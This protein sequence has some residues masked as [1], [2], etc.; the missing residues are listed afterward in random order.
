MSDTLQIQNYI[1]GKL[2][3]PASGQWLDNIE[4]ATGKV[5]SKIPGSDATDVQQAI[6]A[7]TA[8]FTEWSTCGPQAR[9]AVMLRIAQLIE[10]NLE[11]LAQAESRDN[12]KPI[13]LARTVDIP[14]AASN[15]RFFATAILHTESQ[16][17]ETEGIAINYKKNAPKL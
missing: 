8:A 12:G 10:D 3:T 2:T 13:S 14:R 15:F 9:S 17:H 4:P 16:A 5:Y 6:E 1:N 7:A 11:E